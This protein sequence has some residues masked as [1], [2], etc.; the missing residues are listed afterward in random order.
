MDNRPA[1][2]MVST[3]PCGLLFF[4]CRHQAPTHKKGKLH[5]AG[6]DSTSKLI[7][8]LEG[9]E[10]RMTMKKPT[11]DGRQEMWIHIRQGG[12]KPWRKASR[13]LTYSKAADLEFERHLKIS[14]NE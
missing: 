6:P 7:G 2:M 8:S 12:D 10:V 4:D 13:T 9:I 14:N 3:P 1:G 11:K 5:M